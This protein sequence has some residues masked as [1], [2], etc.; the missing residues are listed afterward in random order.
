MSDT[1]V[2]SSTKP[3]PRK[4]LVPPEEQFWKRYSPHYEFPLSVF[5]SI[6]LHTLTFGGV[7]LLILIGLRFLRQDEPLP[8]DAINVSSGGGG[9]PKGIGN[10]PGDGAIPTGPETAQKEQPPKPRTTPIEKQEL[11]TLQRPPVPLTEPNNQDP[12]RAVDVDISFSSKA[13]DAVSQKLRE[14]M[15]Q[16]Q[17]AGQGQ[18]GKG[19]GGGAG[20]GEGPGTGNASGI[21]DGKISTR[22]RRNNRWTLIFNTQDGQ[23]YARQLTAL[24]AILAIKDSSGRFTVYRDLRT[25]PVQ[26]E[27]EDVGL[28]NRIFWIDD[29][30][31]SVSSLCGALGISPVPGHI[32]AFFPQ[33]LEK[34]LLNKELAAFRGNEEDIEE[35]YF[36]V[37]RRG[38]SYEPELVNVKPVTRRRR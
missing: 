28:L 11:N 29:K 24:G 27:I 14:Q 30:P 31:S 10:E 13:L 20:Q 37:S 18:E 9:N 5:S 4:P 22:Q 26:G 21:G 17:F 3:A 8:T 36:R 15:M 7:F 23:D 12:T 19:K 32:Y 16:L 33:E 34:Q 6:L 35:T 2:A 1:A 38:A 25:R